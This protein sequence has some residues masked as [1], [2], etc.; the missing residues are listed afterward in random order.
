M[1]LVSPS[2]QCKHTMKSMHIV[3]CLIRWVGTRWGFVGVYKATQSGTMSLTCWEGSSCEFEGWRW[4]KAP[5]WNGKAGAESLHWGFT[6]DWLRFFL[7]LGPK[8][9][10]AWQMLCPWAAHPSPGTCSASQSH[11]NLALYG[12]P[13]ITKDRSTSSLRSALTW[14][15]LFS[16]PTASQNS[17]PVEKC[18]LCFGKTK[19]ACSCWGLSNIMGS[20]RLSNLQLGTFY[21]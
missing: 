11:P 12:S 21:K 9:P 20:W 10:P 14:V 16:S 8:P 17:G 2:R 13:P 6:L 3:G 1:E 18:S 5:Q 4:V 7:V 15:P 19:A